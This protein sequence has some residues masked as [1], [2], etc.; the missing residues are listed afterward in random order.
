M[1]FVILVI[2]ITI[3]YGLNRDQ[4]TEIGRFI[5]VVNLQFVYLWKFIKARFCLVSGSII[6][7]FILR[8]EDFYVT[9]M[10]R[11]GA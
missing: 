11:G 10:S 3:Q 7:M 4:M 8:L 6:G 2:L 9:E 5:F 1:E